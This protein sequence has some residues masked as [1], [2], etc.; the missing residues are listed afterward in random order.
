MPLR[1]RAAPT[2]YTP[3]LMARTLLP[4]VQLPPAG[5]STTTG[6]ERGSCSTRGRS[7]TPPAAAR[8]HALPRGVRARRPKRDVAAWSGVAQ[9]DF[10]WM[11]SR[12]SPTATR[13]AASCSTS[14]AARCRPPTRRCRR[15]SS[16]TGTSRCSPTP[17]ATGS[18]R[19]R[20]SRCS[21]RSA[22]TRPSPS[23]AASPRAG[24]IEDGR[25]VITPHADFPRAAVREEAL[26]TARFCAP[27]R[28]PR[29]RRSAP[30]RDPLRAAHDAAVGRRARSPAA[31]RGRSAAR[32]PSSLTVFRPAGASRTVRRAIGPALEHERGADRRA[33]L[34]DEHAHVEAAP[35]PGLRRRAPLI[36]GATQRERADG[37]SGRRSPGG[38][39]PPAGSTNSG[40][41]GTSHGSSRPS[42]THAPSWMLSP[43]CAGTAGPT[44]RPARTW[45]DA[46]PRPSAAATSAAGS[47]SRPR[48]G[49]GPPTASARSAVSWSNDGP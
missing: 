18:S 24:A 34:R 33:A 37:S 22:A 30:E 41:V 17:T 14:P 28:P 45:P 31:R 6:A 23:T 39:G 48:A 29:G 26:R 49:A 25:I 11:R 12:P 21:S 36:A 10:A 16:A 1:R 46:R 44:G 19:P 15:A 40:T 7:P 5:T 13:R 20:S 3:I 35:Q 2:A 42:L 8:P 32:T 27:E 4:L 43:V 47:R 38:G 9:S